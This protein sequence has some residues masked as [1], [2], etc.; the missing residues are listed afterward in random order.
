MKFVI[1]NAVN[2][3]CKKYNTRDPFELANCLNI[4]V[5]YHDLHEEINGFYKYEKRNK[6]IAINSNLSS[7]M[8]RTV[9]AHE[10]GHAILHPQANTPF[11]RKNTF[12][13]VDKLEI[14]A[15]IFAALLLIDKDTIIQGDT[16]ACIAY[17]SNIPLELLEFY[18]FD[19][20]KKHIN[21]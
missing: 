8:Q 9:C 21:Y 1:N 6:F 15:N 17:K 10:L 18:T 16:K 13:S 19:Q 20:R 11:L 4:N 12:L 5:F 7:T 3:L 2:Q 14:E